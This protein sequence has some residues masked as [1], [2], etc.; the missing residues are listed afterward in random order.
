MEPSCQLLIFG[1]FWILNYWKR[2][3]KSDFPF[4]FHHQIKLMEIWPFFQKKKWK[5]HQ[6]HN[7]VNFFWPSKVHRKSDSTV[8]FLILNWFSIYFWPPEKIDEL[9]PFFQKKK[10]KLH[11]CWHVEGIPIPSSNSFKV[12]TPCPHKKSSRWGSGGFNVLFR[13]SFS[14]IFCSPLDLG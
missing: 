1:F 13:T 11:Q 10:W 2:F 7:F 12:L 5:L 3:L 8:R 4:T 14:N 6:C 9:W